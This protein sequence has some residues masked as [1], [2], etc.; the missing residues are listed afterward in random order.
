MQVCYN[1]TARTQKTACE[2]L[3]MKY[4]YGVQLMALHADIDAS[5]LAVALGLRFTFS[6]G[7]ST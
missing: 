2:T 1:F 7:Q 4:A 6:L 3:M 5:A